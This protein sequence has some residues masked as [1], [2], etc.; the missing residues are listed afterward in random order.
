MGVVV[1]ALA[2]ILRPYRRSLDLHEELVNT[3]RD[4]SVP[5]DTAR[6]AVRRWIEQPWLE[7]ESWDAKWEDLCEVEV[8]RW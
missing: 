2:E 4:H 3:L 5:F 6:D 1:T 8:E 7:E